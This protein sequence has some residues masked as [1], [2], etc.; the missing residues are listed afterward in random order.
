M[1][2]RIIRTLPRLQPTLDDI[3]IALHQHRRQ[4]LADLSQ[5]IETRQQLRLE[6]QPRIDLQINR[7][8]GAEALLR[9]RHPVFGPLPPADFIPIAESDPVIV[10]LTDWVLDTAVAFAASVARANRQIRISVN[11]SPKNLTAGYF[12][13]RLVEALGR[14]NLDPVNLELEFTESALISDGKRTRQQLDQIR[15]MGVSVSIDDF[16]AGYSNLSYL[17]QVPADIIKIDR[18]LVSAIGADREN[19]TIVK[20]II[21]LANELGLR[22]VAEGIDTDQK[23]T[24]L[25]SWGC[26][27]GQGFALAT[28]MAQVKLV[29]WIERY[30]CLAGDDRVIRLPFSRRKNNASHLAHPALPAKAAVIG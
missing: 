22:V 11:I 30:N 14:H 15:R 28:P 29:S 25:A 21:G 8:V 24:T 5:A 18:K 17:R 2:R 3:P 23:A 26:H 27:E 19:D 20:W 12:V 1:R 4:L 9:W 16:G 6:Y 13:G 10:P 7:C